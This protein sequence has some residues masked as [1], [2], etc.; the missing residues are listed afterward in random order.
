MNPKSTDPSS[1]HPA[2]DIKAEIKPDAEKISR[3]KLFKRLVGVG[4]FAIAGGMYGREVEPYWVKW[5]EVKM[6]IRNLPAS[7]KGFRITQLTDLHAGDIVP[8]SHLRRTVEHV[9]NVIKPDMVVVTGDLVNDSAHF[10]KPVVELL[11]ELQQAGIP[12]ISILGNH[13][14]ET[15]YEKV[16]VHHDL[17]DMLQEQ[18][19]A[20]G[21]I[22]LRNSST[23]IIKGKDRMWFVG[24]EDLWSGQ[25]SPQLAF[26]GVP[27]N[28]PVIALSH[29]PDTAFEMDSFGA[30]LTLSGHTH[31]GQVCIP[32]VGALLINIQNSQF[33][34]GQFKL[35]NG[36]L[37]V[38]R[39]VGFLKKLRV[40]CRPEVPTF[41]LE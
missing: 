34:Q 13:D 21:M 16:S 6:P 10:V 18:I 36:S 41:V 9:K 32:G 15:D 28:E 39:G 17:A 27:A 26:Q 1:M 33:Q 2:I 7:F 5:H 22:L 23:S 29:N 8:F 3:R 38:S 19:K 14:Y 24:L 25:Y 11:A 40:F 30:N 20:S 12:V 35:T 4:S 37:Y 31:G